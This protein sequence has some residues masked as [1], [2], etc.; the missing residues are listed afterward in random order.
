MRYQGEVSLYLQA[1]PC[2]ET[3][4]LI[5]IPVRGPSILDTARIVELLNIDPPF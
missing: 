1:L 4:A 2:I 3:V 5:G